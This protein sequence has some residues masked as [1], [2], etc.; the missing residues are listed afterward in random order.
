MQNIWRK[1]KKTL[2]N[3][4]D[5]LYN[6]KWLIGTINACILCGLR[7]SRAITTFSSQE[8]PICW[9]LSRY[10]TIRSQTSQSVHISYTQY[11]RTAYIFWCSEL[12]WKS[13]LSIKSERLHKR[14]HLTRH[15]CCI[16]VERSNLEAKLGALPSFA[17]LRK[18]YCLHHRVSMNDTI[19]TLKCI[20]CALISQHYMMVLM[21]TLQLLL[22]IIGEKSFQF[23]LYNSALYI[24]YIVICYIFFS[25]LP[26]HR[27]SRCVFSLRYSTSN[28][29]KSKVLYGEFVCGFFFFIIIISSIHSSFSA[30]LLMLLISFVHA[31]VTYFLSLICMVW[32]G[33]CFS[34]EPISVYP[35]VLFIILFFI[36]N[37]RP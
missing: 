36:M 35:T 32:F 18:N 20:V 25:S 31:R 14:S 29:L 22:L 34:F 9:V 12:T 13:S 33:N 24:V 11:A 3:E 27:W 10:K 2:S 16:S 5:S 7:I 21:Y 1:E 8:I 19:L 26:F 28:G 15:L 37:T 17:N 4:N 23:A 30:L 6:I